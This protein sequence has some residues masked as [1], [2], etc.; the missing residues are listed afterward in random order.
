MSLFQLSPE[1]QQL[2]RSYVEY[3]LQ[4]QESQ[5]QAYWNAIGRSVVAQI[6]PERR[7]EFT[8][9]V[10]AKGSR[11]TRYSQDTTRQALIDEFNYYTVD[12]GL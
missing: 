9:W 11:V 3:A 6:I 7:R 4:Q 10:E 2:R 8:K 12:E 1:Q 5:S